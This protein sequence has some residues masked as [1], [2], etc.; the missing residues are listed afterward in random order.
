M[1]ET[2]HPSFYGD[3]D[4]LTEFSKLLSTDI[5][6][7]QRGQALTKWSEYNRER[8]YSLSIFFDFKRPDGKTLTDTV[9]LL[10][11]MSRFII[12]DLSAP[13]SSPLEVGI[14]I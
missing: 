2:Q 1:T 3:K 9:K 6:T 7:E 5:H 11:Q 10:A 4:D 13:S 8:N 12:V 14:I